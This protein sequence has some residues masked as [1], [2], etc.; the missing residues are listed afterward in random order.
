MGQPATDDG[1]NEEILTLCISCGRIKGSGGT[2]RDIAEEDGVVF[3]H[4]LCFPC[5][6]ELYP[7]FFGDSERS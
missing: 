2:W 1:T 6:E 5:A 7:Q 4:G 3:S